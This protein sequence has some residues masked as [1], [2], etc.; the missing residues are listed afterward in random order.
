MCRLDPAET[1]LLLSTRVVLASAADCE[2]LPSNIALAG[3]ACE[4]LGGSAGRFDRSE[5]VE[6]GLCRLPCWR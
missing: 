3:V 4:R 1:A 5:V 6:D 2:R